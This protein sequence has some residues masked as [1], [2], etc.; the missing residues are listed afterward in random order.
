[1]QN[2]TTSFLM[3]CQAGGDGTTRG[4]DVQLDIL[5]R[6]FAAEK[7]HLRNDDVRDVVVDRSS[8]ENDVVAK[9]TAIDVV[10]ALATTRLLDHH[11]Y[12]SHNALFLSR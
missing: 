1:M 5:L 7:Q 9:Q 4:V 6:V 8:Q 2:V 10:G 3:Y 12:Q 11:R